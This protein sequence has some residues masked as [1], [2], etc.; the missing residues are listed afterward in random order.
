MSF[1]KRPSIVALVLAYA[2][3]LGHRRDAG[4]SSP[5][6]LE[7]TE[8]P[9]PSVALRVCRSLD[10]HE[11]H[12]HFP[13]ELRHPSGFLLEQP[14]HHGG[15]SHDPHGFLLDFHAAVEFAGHRVT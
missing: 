10:D 12:D 8:I 15:V 9:H 3:K 4:I 5:A 6:R 2:G 1:G 11:S 13:N 7:R 14:G